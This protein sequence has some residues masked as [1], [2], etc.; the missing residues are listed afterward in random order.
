MI[1]TPYGDLS[2]LSTGFDVEAH[3][4][5]LVHDTISQL[6]TCVSV[7]RNVLEDV[8]IARNVLEDAKS[9]YLGGVYI[10]LEPFLKRYV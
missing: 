5:A 7:A 1:K 10:H 8:N 3:R 9:L 2:W 4:K 6:L